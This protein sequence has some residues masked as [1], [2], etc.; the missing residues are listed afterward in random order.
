[1]FV[2]GGA[3]GL[4]PGLPRS[5]AGPPVTTPAGHEATGLIPAH[6]MT[7]SLG[8]R[9]AASQID[10][11]YRRIPQTR[12]VHPFPQARFAATY[13]R[14]ESSVVIPHAGIC[15]EGRPQ[16]QS[17]LRLCMTLRRRYVTDMRGIPRSSPE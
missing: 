10:Q 3:I 16:G 17:L 13:R 12:T 7:G 14:Y 15:A 1:M 4:Y 2:S 9:R 5:P 6:R 8:L 11:P